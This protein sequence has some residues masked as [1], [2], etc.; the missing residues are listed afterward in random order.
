MSELWGMFLDA[1]LGSRCPI[2]GQRVFPN[3]RSV[4]AWVDHGDELE[5]A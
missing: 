1:L 2:C 5:A 3:D 4:H